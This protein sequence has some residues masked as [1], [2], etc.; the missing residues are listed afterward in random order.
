MHLKFLLC[1]GVS[2]LL[3]SGCGLKGPLYI[4]KD[5]GGQGQY[6]TALVNVTSPY[7]DAKDMTRNFADEEGS[8]VP[9]LSVSNIQAD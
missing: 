9:W 5:E 6:Q 8:Y 4:P 3:L 7:H 2:A 1:L